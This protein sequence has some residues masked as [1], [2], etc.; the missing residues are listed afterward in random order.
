MMMMT[1]NGDENGILIAVFEYQT[2]RSDNT[3]LD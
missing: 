3:Q 2:K 1:V